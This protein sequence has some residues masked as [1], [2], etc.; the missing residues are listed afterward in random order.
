MKYVSSK[1]TVICSAREDV[2]STNIRIYIGGG[3]IRKA[4]SAA[5]FDVI[6][7]SKGIVE[8][9]KIKKGQG[10]TQRTS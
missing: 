5:Y 2:E 6:M 1:C 7:T 3:E 4:M 10:A 9:Y 8:D